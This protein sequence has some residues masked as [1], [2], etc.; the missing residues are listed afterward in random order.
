M[1][2]VTAGD[3]VLGD[4]FAYLAAV[5]GGERHFSG[6]QRGPRGDAKDRAGEVNQLVAF[7]RR[8]ADGFEPAVFFVVEN[9][10]G[11]DLAGAVVRDRAGQAGALGESGAIEGLA[12][13]GARSALGL[14]KRFL[15]RG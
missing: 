13:E 8:G 6:G 11:G 12:A 9:D 1:G 7:R 5:L 4:Q 3:A 10:A 14:R 2:H 15:K